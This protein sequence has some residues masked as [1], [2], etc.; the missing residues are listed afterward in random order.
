MPHVSDYRLFFLGIPRIEGDG[1]PIDLSSAKSIALLGYLAVTDG[2]IL[3]ERL[4][5][6]L[7]PSSSPDAARKNLRNT[8]WSIRKALGETA[9][10]GDDQ[11][12]QLNPSLWTDVRELRRA[13]AD[14]AAI[15]QT[16][17]ASDIYRGPFL[18]G[19]A[20]DD[21]PDYEIWLTSQR[22]QLAQT[23]LRVLADRAQAEAAQGDWEAVIRTASRA[24][25]YDNLQ[26]PMYRALMQAYAQLGARD[27]A[28]KVYASLKVVIERE[29]GVEPLA[30]ST[31]LRDAILKGEYD[32]PRPA[33]A[34]R[35]KRKTSQSEAY[36][37]SP[38]VGR[39]QDRAALGAVLRNVEKGRAQVV[40]LSGELGIGKS[41]LWQEWARALPE[42]TSILETR[43]LES[44]Q[45]LPL[46]PVVE[47]LRE[48]P[49]E[50]VLSGPH[51]RLARVWL[52]EV[53]RLAPELC[54]RDTAGPT[55]T[56]AL[57]PEEERRRLFEAL[58]RAVEELA[59]PIVL[60]VDDVQWADSAT[61]DWLDYAVHRLSDTPLLL[62]L[63]LR[64][65]DTPEPLARL[66]ARWT[67]EGIATRH[68]LVRLSQQESEQLAGALGVD[69]SAAGRIFSK[70]AGNPYFMLELIRALPNDDLPPGL[71]ELLHARLER[72][73]ETTRQVL[74]AAAVLDAGY[75]FATLRQT[76]GRG[77][78]ETVDAVDVLVHVGILQERDKDYAF[79]HP[80]V[81]EVVRQGLSGAR[82]AFLHRRAARAME[83]TFGARPGPGAGSIAAHYAQGGEPQQAARFAEM[84]AEHALSL[85]APAEAA[86]FYR[87]ALEWEPTAAR[88]LGLGRALFREGDLIQARG[89][90]DASMQESLNSGD[91]RGAG[92][93]ALAVAETFFPSGLF[94]EGNR[95]VEKAVELIGDQQDPELHALAHL[96][97]GVSE[98]DRGN[99]ERAQKQLAEGA[100]HAQEHS[101]YAPGGR[102]N[103]MLGNVLAESGD[104]A[105]ALESYCRSLESAERAG[106]EF[107]QA[108]ALNN[109][110]Y[111]S[112]LA[113]DLAA[114]H[115]Y[116]DDGLALAD[117]RALRVPLQH[118]YSTAGEIALA[119]RD[120]GKA[121]DWFE[122]GITEAERNENVREVA[123]YRANLALAAQGRDDL[124]AAVGL[125]ESARQGA[126]PVTDRHL[127]IKIDLAL[128]ELYQRRGER[129]AA[130]E[131]L[132]RAERQLATS[133]RRLQ[134][135]WAARLR[136]QL[137]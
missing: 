104:I 39:E 41:R 99:L 107:Q 3:R 12:L 62:V 135:E 65:E 34:D 21:A 20:L 72:L 36:R 131:A 82:R 85:A 17:A 78:E 38:F 88:H 133:P 47:L 13:A 98:S 110:A 79:T 48:S 61:I 97:R 70:S 10:V 26:E 101:L 15:G 55:A 122:R 93:A 30:E 19:L 68:G 119:E 51:P 92:R 123:N 31:A 16:P 120:W 60:F 130:R 64:P 115:R 136:K 56:T 121:E 7:W 117:T 46:A 73:P 127:K 103:F 66:L 125:L 11:S 6:L 24:L 25:S 57:P 28:L 53:A 106:D 94:E 63:A 100:R 14:L 74:Q 83:R 52:T 29:L 102:L 89:A 81:G 75:D 58:T 67:R 124:D 71:A 84:A 5:D 59:T 113:G 129:A 4:L 45:R 49:L 23:E 111:H 9:I 77:E 43:C 8:L 2:P 32:Q 80:L 109:L 132:A 118:L 22:E 108:L 116:V 27:Q 95:W 76:S 69:P 96:L 42:G 40:V 90:F 35:Y 54:T 128:A 137:A 105:G 44:T 134:Q 126:A 37:Q 1:R 112:V 86:A 18:D 50:P 91:R 87:Q 114:A 33:T